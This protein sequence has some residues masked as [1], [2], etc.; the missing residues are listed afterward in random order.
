EGDAPPAPLLGI[1]LE[2]RLVCIVFADEREHPLS[3]LRLS[4]RPLRWTASLQTPGPIAVGLGPCTPQGSDDGLPVARPLAVPER[5]SRP[6]ADEG[7]RA[8]IGGHR[9]T[10]DT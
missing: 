10:K 4:E 6:L 1:S 7:A 8:R 2:K 5:S 3:R 9:T